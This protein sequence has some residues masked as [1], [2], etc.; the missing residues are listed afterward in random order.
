MLPD[1]IGK[2]RRGVTNASR[3]DCSIVSDNEDAS[4]DSNERHSRLG[5]TGGARGRAVASGRVARARAK[6]TIMKRPRE[7]KRARCRLFEPFPRLADR[8]FCLVTPGTKSQFWIEKSAQISEQ[9]APADC[10]KRQARALLVRPLTR[11]FHVTAMA[12]TTVAPLAFAARVAGTRLDSRR[13]C[14][15]RSR[16]PAK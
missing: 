13:R 14:V 3:G 2:A 7:R 8:R 10:F 12:S 15:V 1:G 11:L 9:K 16:V 4:R 6:R 5:S